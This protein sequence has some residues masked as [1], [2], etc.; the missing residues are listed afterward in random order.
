VVTLARGGPVPRTKGGAVDL[1]A[2]AAELGVHYQT[3]W[4][5]VRA[6]LLPAARVASGY[7]LDPTHVASF[8]KTRYGPRGEPRSDGAPELGPQ[9]LAETLLAGDE[10]T[11][12]ALVAAAHEAGLGPVALCEDLILPAVRAVEEERVAGGLSA[13]GRSLAESICERLVG[14]LAFPPQGR[15]RGSAVVAGPEPFGRRLPGLLVTVA[16]RSDRWRV[17]DLGAN[18]PA[19][20]IL[21]FVGE[22]R[23]DVVVLAG[24]SGGLQ[25]ADLN[26]TVEAVSAVPVLWYEP[27]TSLPELVALVRRRATFQRQKS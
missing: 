25:P 21:E 9:K 27:D 23:P 18:V 15:P 11:A 13:A 8:A 14:L 12:R 16:L 5:W 19:P 6:G 26:A 24:P 3:A 10:G 7:E 2:A 1:E 22:R 4:R 17:H 20:E